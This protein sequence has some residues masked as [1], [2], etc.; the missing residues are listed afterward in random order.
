M[1]TYYNYN[2]LKEDNQEL[3][4]E[5][6]NKKGAGK[7]Q[8]DTIYLYDDLTDFAEFEVVDGWYALR[9]INIDFNGAPNLFNYIDY[10]RLGEDLQSC[11]DES[12]NYLS[13][14]NQVLTTGYGW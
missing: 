5:L 2:E 3:A 10:E 4:I 14:D 13:E 12:C 8:N 1:K 6:L 9:H 7:W 11:W